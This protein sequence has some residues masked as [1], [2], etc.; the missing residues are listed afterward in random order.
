MNYH[1]DVWVDDIIL[2]KLFCEFFFKWIVLFTIVCE[3]M[4]IICEL[5]FLINEQQSDLSRNELYLGINKNEAWKKIR[6]VRNFNS[7]PQRYQCIA[8]PIITSQHNDQFPGGLL[9]QLV[10]HCIRIAEVMGSNLVKIQA[11]FSLLL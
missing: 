2:K 1:V 9:A 7:R 6:S 3:Y 11:L 8:L 4:K 5:R 10:E